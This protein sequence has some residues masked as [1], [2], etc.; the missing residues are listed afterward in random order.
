MQSA[1]PTSN[2]TIKAAELELKK[3]FGF[4]AGTGASHL[5]KLE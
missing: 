4:G 1:E 2:I 5:K 3:I